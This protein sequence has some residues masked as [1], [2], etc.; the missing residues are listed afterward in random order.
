MINLTQFQ[1]GECALRP[2]HRPRKSLLIRLALAISWTKTPRFVLPEMRSFHHGRINIMISSRFIGI[3]ALG[4]GLS[5][6]GGG[7]S[8]SEQIAESDPMAK[9][10]GEY[11]ICVGH[12]REKMKISASAGGVVQATLEDT[13]FK[14]DNCTG[15]VVGVR[16]MSAPFTL[17]WL[18]TTTV[19]LPPTQG[20]PASDVVDKMQLSAPARTASL[21]GSGVRGLCVE[22]TGGRTCWGSGAY[23]AFSSD[24]AGYLKGE[25]L[26]F[27]EQIGAELV[28]DSLYS[29]RQ[30]FVLNQYPFATTTVTPTPVSPGAAPPSD[31]YA[32]FR[33][34]C[35]AGV[36]SMEF[37][38][39]NGA[40]GG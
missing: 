40:F 29:T 14:N 19:K 39:K 32:S 11:Y 2:L 13:I 8:S 5:A 26:L 23:S 36:M 7:G 17:R 3:A 22:Y 15:E 18:G 12:S 35:N 33:A 21:T 6:C 20:F 37:C 1:V 38:L 9:Y 34:L 31:F 28:T 24:G 4:V 25:Y 30:S 27:F 10:I 16:T